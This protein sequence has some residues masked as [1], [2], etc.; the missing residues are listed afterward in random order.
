MEGVAFAQRESAEVLA[1][2]G[3]PVRSVITAGG[4][5]RSAVWRGIQAGVLGVPVAYY[6]A[7]GGDPEAPAREQPD[8][9]ALGAAILAGVGAGL[10]GSLAGGAA[11]VRVG[12]PDVIDPDPDDVPGYQA[13]FARYREVAREVVPLRKQP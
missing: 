12:D 6:P 7:P 9:S 4:G 2:L 11:L 1:G 5:A 10:F 8:S 3:V 13:A